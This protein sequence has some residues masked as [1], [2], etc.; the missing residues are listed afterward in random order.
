MTNEEIVNSFRTNVVYQMSLTSDYKNWNLKNSKRNDFVV[1]LN[2]IFDEF[3]KKIKRFQLYFMNEIRKVAMKHKSS[4]FQE[5]LL[6]R[7]RDR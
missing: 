7:V 2:T 4:A 3:Q 1:E 5:D 6:V